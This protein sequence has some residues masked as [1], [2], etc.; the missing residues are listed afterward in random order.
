MLS[1]QLRRLLLDTDCIAVPGLGCF[2]VHAM[3]A[4]Y[5]EEE[6]VLVAPS[7][8]IS[9]HSMALGEDSRLTQA[10]MVA[11]DA[12]HHEAE[13][14]LAL[15]VSEL[16]RNIQ[17]L[18]EVTLEG[19][20]TL[21]LTYSGHYH[22]APSHTGKYSGQFLGL[23]SIICPLRVLSLQEEQPTPKLPI[24]VWR[25]V[26]TVT[27]ESLKYAAIFVIAVLSYLMVSYPIDVTSEGQA[28]RM[29]TMASSLVFD[30]YEG[31]P[32]T[33]TSAAHSIMPPVQQD[34]TPA[35]G[36]QQD[37]VDTDSSSRQPQY[38]IVLASAI[39]RH[40]AVLMQQRLE[41]KGYKDVSVMQNKSMVRVILGHYATAREAQ[42]MANE[43]HHNT[44]P[45][46]K[47]AWVMALP[48]K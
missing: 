28:S 24:H 33:T 45:D 47:S 16:K 37:E 18:G 4:R 36:T 29:A 31:L 42:Q 43:L 2:V 11:L 27:K 41:A 44:N 19:I 23:E 8:T 30:R 12:S 7:R 3:P 14:R 20:G 39:T 22:F 34:T 40:N 1:Q 32:I 17:R 48:T 35:F 21:S 6:G 26:A 38:T 10:Y 15:D 46:V 5:L 13:Q 25:K 9:F